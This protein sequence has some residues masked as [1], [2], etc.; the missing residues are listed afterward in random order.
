M[1]LLFIGG[2]VAGTCG[3][4]FVLA[5]VSARHCA[6]CREYYSRQIE[7]LWKEKNQ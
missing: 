5:L 7:A 2:L 1:I 3:G 4:F 6:E